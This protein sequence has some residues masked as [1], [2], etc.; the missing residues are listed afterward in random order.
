MKNV[1]WGSLPYGKNKKAYGND[2]VS[3]SL[4]CRSEVGQFGFQLIQFL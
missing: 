1:L 3:V 4:F 2:I